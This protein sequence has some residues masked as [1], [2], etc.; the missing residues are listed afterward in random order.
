M[1]QECLSGLRISN[2]AQAL[3]SNDW[4]TLFAM[5]DD[6]LTHLFTTLKYPAPSVT[7]MWDYSS[8][9]LL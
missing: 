5:A 2:K 8:I 6:S 7:G 4:K 9:Q 3:S 1:C